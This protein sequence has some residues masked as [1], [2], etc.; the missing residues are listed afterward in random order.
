MS[1]SNVRYPFLDLRK[2]DA[3]LHGRLAEAAARVISSGRYIGGK[4]VER[5]EERMCVLTGAASAAGTG[6]GLDALRLALRACVIEGLLKEGD[7]VVV[8]ANTYI[9]SVLAVT[10]AGLVPKLVDPDEST[11]CLSGEGVRKALSPKVKAIMPVHLYG[12][13]AWDATMADLAREHDLLVIEDA[14]QSI[15]AATPLGGMFHSGTAGAIGHIGAISFYPTKNVGAIGDAGMILTN[16]PQVAVTARA[17]ANYGS[18]RRYH[19]IYRGFNSRLDPIQAAIIG[20]RLEE[21]E[22]ICREREAIARIYSR[23]ISNPHVKLPALTTSPRESVWHQY[24][25]RTPHRDALRE[26]LIGRGVQTDIHYAVPPHLQPCYIGIRHTPLP[27]TERLASEVLSLPVTPGST[28][29][30]DA[31]QISE[32]I[33][34]FNPKDE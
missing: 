30:D 16:I 10:D 24:V 25:I 6:N 22:E 7:E 20:V 15:G 17:L 34:E 29:R 13:V 18:D 3:H 9:A 4:E 23:S 1:N 26:Y 33:N 2:A 5:L 19:N 28:S 14:A 12:R 21:L 11:M 27:V 8:P 31:R 32:I